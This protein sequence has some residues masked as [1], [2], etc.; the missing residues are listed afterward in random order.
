MNEDG[1]DTPEA[2]ADQA[3]EGLGGDESSNVD[4]NSAAQLVDS[5]ADQDMGDAYW[6]SI[7]EATIDTTPTKR[8]ASQSP[9]VAAP[10]PAVAA[11]DVTSLDPFDAHLNDLVKRGDGWDTFFDVMGDDFVGEICEA[12][13]V[14]AAG[15]ALYDLGKC[16]FGGS[17]GSPPQV[18]ITSLLGT[19]SQEIKYRSKFSEGLIYSTSKASIAVASEGAG[20][21]LQSMKLEGKVKVTPS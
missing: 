9:T 19:G 18:T 14:I 2:V 8:D 3:V 13:Q 7:Q 21:D 12:C 4:A 11:R 16:I 10:L 1:L 5:D 17:C 6:D 15:K 20:I